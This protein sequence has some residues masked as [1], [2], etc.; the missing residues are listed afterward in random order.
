VDEIELFMAHR[1][2]GA[3]SA[4]AT[5]AAVAVLEAV[6]AAAAVL[7]LLGLPRRL[8]WRS[9]TSK[10]SQFQA[11]GMCSTAHMHKILKKQHMQTQGQAVDDVRD[12]DLPHDSSAAVLAASCTCDGKLRKRVVLQASC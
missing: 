8:L 5:L 12:T 2:Y 9:A 1:N 6:A 4:A 10:S 3:N 7:L 11:K